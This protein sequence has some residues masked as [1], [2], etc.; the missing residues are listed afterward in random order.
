MPGTKNVLAPGD[1]VL[2]FLGSHG[3]QGQVIKVNRATVKVKY[4]FHG[5]VFIR[6]MA[7]NRVAHTSD[8]CTIVCDI[9][10]DPNG[11]S[12][13]F[14]YDTFPDHRTRVSNWDGQYLHV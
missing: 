14:E 1:P 10:K 4:F 7:P 12:V 6:N 8:V 3:I 5:Q 2:V 13:R 11:Q 9:T